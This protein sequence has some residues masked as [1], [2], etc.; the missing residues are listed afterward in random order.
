MKLILQM[1]ANVT[2]CCREAWSSIT[3]LF[4]RNEYFLLNILAGDRKSLRCPEFNY[5]GCSGEEIREVVN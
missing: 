5:K 3:L 2:H 1:L 4:Y